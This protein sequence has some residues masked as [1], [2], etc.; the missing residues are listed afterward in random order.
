MVQKENMTDAMEEKLIAWTRRR[1]VTILIFPVF[2]W[3][4]QSWR[5]AK[6]TLHYPN[7]ISN[8]TGCHEAEAF[9]EPWAYHSVSEVIPINLV[10]I[11][12]CWGIIKRRL[13][14]LHMWDRQFWAL[15]KCVCQHWLYGHTV[16]QLRWNYSEFQTKLRL[17]VYF[18]PANNN[19]ILK[20]HFLQLYCMCLKRK[21]LDLLVF[22]LTH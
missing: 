1:Y 6:H 13:K 18:C 20:H 21:F 4:A 19:Q 10:S 7:P 8:I 9:M 2:T 11:L 3:A 12:E 5:L 22:V 17:V 15:Y 16:M 14:I